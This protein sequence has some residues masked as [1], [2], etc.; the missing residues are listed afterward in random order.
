M[1]RH[2]EV[3][4]ASVAQGLLRRSR[5]ELRVTL[6]LESPGDVGRVFTEL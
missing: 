2:S 4:A 6:T 1:V 5:A 3:E